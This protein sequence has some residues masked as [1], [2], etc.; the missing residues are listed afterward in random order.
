[1]HHHNRRNG[2]HAGA[3]LATGVVA[4]AA[5]TLAFVAAQRFFGRERVRWPEDAPARA[6]KGGE[7]GW[8]E[9]RIV[10]RTVT[11]D[12]PRQELYDFWRDFTRLPQFMENLR[13]VELL[14]EDRSRWTIEAP[15]GSEVS[16]VS[17]I[18]EDRPGELIAWS[19]E[20]GADIRNSGR[21]AFRDAPGGRGTQVD[22][23]IAYD[24]PGGR[25]G[26]LAAKIMQR[27]PNIQAR[28]DLKRFKQFMEAGEIATAAP[29]PDHSKT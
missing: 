7:R 13:S 17:R 8:R 2:R 26:E 19:S 27:E 11:I 22:L 12:R 4:M 10:G 21:V 1:M 14:G 5:G 9:Q 20:E 29:R 24:P 23:T 15:G 18:T 25:I 28:R 3:G 6:R 16:F